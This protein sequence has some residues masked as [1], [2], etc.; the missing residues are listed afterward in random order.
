VTFVDVSSDTRLLDRA[1][2]LSTD[3]RGDAGL[4]RLRRGET[5]AGARDAA[6]AE[7]ARSIVRRV[8]EVW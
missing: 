8:V 2:V 5:E 4:F 3:T 6:A 7:L 1:S